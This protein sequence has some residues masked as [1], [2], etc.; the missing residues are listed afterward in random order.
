MKRL[1]IAV[2]LLLA[3]LGAT[4]GNSFYLK[5]LNEELSTLLERADRQAAMGNWDEAALF[6]RTAREQWQSHDFYLHVTL[7]HNDVD[8]IDSDFQELSALLEHRE[9]GEYSAVLS[10]LSSRLRLI[11]EGETL[12]LQNVF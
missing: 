9:E 4:L 2:C 11:Y 12:S 6:V 10:R 1:M 5:G 3:V 8:Q 7:R